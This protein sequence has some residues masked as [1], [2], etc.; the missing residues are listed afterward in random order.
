MYRNIDLIGVTSYIGWYEFP[1][2][3]H[4]AKV[5]RIRGLKGVVRRLRS[6]LTLTGG[7]TL[8]AAPRP[9]RAEQATAAS[10]A[11]PAG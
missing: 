9:H 1:F 5:A 3:S 4:A 10:L 7:T 8:R 6:H 2:L 11:A